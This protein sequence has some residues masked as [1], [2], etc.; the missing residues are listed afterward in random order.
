VFLPLLGLVCVAAILFIPFHN[1]FYPRVALGR[2]SIRLMRSS[3]TEPGSFLLA[4]G[5][6]AFILLGYY[7]A[8]LRKMAG[9]RGGPSRMVS[10]VFVLVLALVWVTAPAFFSTFRGLAALAALLAGIAVYRAARPMPWIA[11]FILAAGCIGGAEWITRRVEPKPGERARSERIDV[12]P[13]ESRVIPFSAAGYDNPW[14]SREAAK[15]ALKTEV[16]PPVFEAQPVIEGFRERLTKRAE[17]RAHLESEGKP[18]PP[19]LKEGIFDRLQA[20]FGPPYWRT[21]ETLLGQLLWGTYASPYYGTAALILPWIVLSLFLIVRRKDENREVLGQILVLVALSVF[22]GIE[23]FYI[24]E[25]WG[26]PRHRWNT[27]FKFFMEIWVYLSLGAASLLSFYRRPKDEGKRR[28]SFASGLKTG[29]FYGG[30][31]LVLLTAFATT[32]FAPYALI[33]TPGSPDIRGERPS[34]DGLGFVKTITPRVP[35]NNQWGEEELRAVR[36]LRRFVYGQPTLLEGDCQT[37]PGTSYD[38]DY[39]A[40]RIATYTGIPTVLGWE[41]HTK[42]RGPGGRLKPAHDRDMAARNADIREIYTSLNHDRVA[43]LLRERNVD[44]VYLGYLEQM[45][46]GVSVFQRFRSYAD[47][48]DPIYEHGPIR[49][50]RVRD[51]PVAP[52][53]DIGQPEFSE[54]VALGEHSMFL[55]G[56]GEGPGYFNVPVGLAVG[57]G[58]RIAV[59]D[60][61]NHRIQVF[62]PEGRPVLVFGSE[63]G[64]PGG[65]EEPHDVAFDRDG[66]IYVADTWNHR[67]S[68]FSPDGTLDREFSGEFYGPRGIAVDA[69]G[70]RIYVADTGRH[71]VRVLNANGEILRIGEQGTEEGKLWEPTGIALGP[72]GEIVVAEMLNARISVFDPNGEFLRVLRPPFPEDN[73]SNEMHVAVS[74][75]GHVYLTDSRYGR[76]IHMTL[77]GDLVEILNVRE[78][79]A[80]RVGQPLGIVRLPDG[81]L[82]VADGADDRIVRSARAYP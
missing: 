64:F 50:Y 49:I 37:R 5:V 34:L 44:L 70:E 71:T 16:R 57:P 21:R 15:G 77:G 17:E 24:F 53:P 32:V 2:E 4:F 76:I 67:V 8:R 20:L 65:F 69:N 45:K 40:A 38:N 43:E 66:N 63:G 58:G 13:S 80:F 6:F 39:P 11:M 26:P 68:R 72:N 22:L 60:S 29:V 7:L 61:K 36:W 52:P 51:E 59:A 23:I 33:A 30:V 18:V 9:N 31:V 19:Y 82:L 42:E 46:Y 14:I 74:E 48:L 41:H 28:S 62:S 54:S 25:D 79:T 1:S 81:F 56:K 73:S 27:V 55:G 35:D 75:K 10:W 78:D 47:I 3:W 12:S